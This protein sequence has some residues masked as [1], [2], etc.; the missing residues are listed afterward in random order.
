VEIETVIA[1]SIEPRLIDSFGRE[2]ANALLTQATIRYVTEKGKERERCK[3]F[4]H[5][6]C[7]DA[8]VIEAWGTEAAAEQA[9]R[10]SARIHSESDSVG[11]P[12]KEK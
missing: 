9:K 8:R 12:E 1:E 5:S 4:V 3:A 6:I 2:I 10:W 7:F 11:E